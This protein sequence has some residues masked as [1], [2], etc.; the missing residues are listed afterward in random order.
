MCSFRWGDLGG[1]LV[2]VSLLVPEYL[3]S[4]SVRREG[5]VWTLSLRMQHV[6]L[7]KTQREEH[8]RMLTSQPQTG[9]REMNAAPAGFLAFSFLFIG[10]PSP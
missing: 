9:S 10:D 1:V 7:V 5:F 3:T 4:S 8:L 2:T 6:M